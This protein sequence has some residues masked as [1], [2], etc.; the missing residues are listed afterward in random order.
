MWN[1]F[2]MLRYLES[3]LDIHSRLNSSDEM[4]CMPVIKRF[5]DNMPVAC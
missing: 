1:D 2:E 3:I 5:L 4:P